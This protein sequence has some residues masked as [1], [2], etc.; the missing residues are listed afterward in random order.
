MDA[1]L[2]AMR[3]RGASWEIVAEYI[4]VTTMAVIRRARA[5]GVPTARMNHGRVPGHDM[6]SAHAR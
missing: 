5:L 3:A 2:L 1:A 4:G 6:V